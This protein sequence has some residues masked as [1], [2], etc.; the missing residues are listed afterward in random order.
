MIF[1]ILEQ[2][3]ALRIILASTSP[4]RSDMLRSLGLSFTAVGSS[5]A[6]DLDKSQYD[7]PQGYVMETAKCKALAVA[8]DMKDRADLVIGCDTIVVSNQK[9]LEKPTDDADAVRMLTSLSG[10]THQVHT[11]VALVV[12]KGS[13]FDVQQAPPTSDDSKDFLF[14]PIRDGLLQGVKSGGGK[15]PDKTSSSS[16]T[17][18]RSTETRDSVV[19]ALLHSFVSTTEV[20]FDSLSLETIEAYVRTGEPRDKAGAYGIQ[21]KGGSLISGVKGCPFNVIGFPLHE[22]TKKLLNLSRSLRTT[23]QSVGVKPKS[24]AC[25]PNADNGAVNFVPREHV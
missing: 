17:T 7:S 8:R 5:F 11:G 9:I 25:V 23:S 10:K 22:F 4:R 12:P 14:E 13:A 15:S 24:D 1:H 6:E 2:L 20:T 19:V 18:S 16:D 3:N 21:G